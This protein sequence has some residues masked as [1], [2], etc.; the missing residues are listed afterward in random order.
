[1]SYKATISDINLGLFA[2]ADAPSAEDRFYISATDLVTTRPPRVLKYGDTFVVLDS[3]GDIAASAG[4]SAGLFDHDT[5]FLSRLELLVNGMHPLLLGSNLRDDNSAFLV[6]L[7]NPDVIYD[8][9]VVMEKDTVHILRTISY[10]TASRISVYACATTAI[11]RSNSSFRYSS[12]TTLPTCSRFGGRN[13]NGEA[14]QRRNCAAMI[15]FCSPTPGSTGKCGEP[16]SPSIR[17]R[18]T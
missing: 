1:M 12:R 2:I 8:K 9:R 6:D 4:G 14:A 15:R 17:I 3:R 11:S 5:R 10:G 18:N 7:T 13:A 16:C